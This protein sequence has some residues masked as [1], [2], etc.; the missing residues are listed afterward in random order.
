MTDPDRLHTREFA[1]VAGGPA[2]TR[3]GDGAVG[4]APTAL[5]YVRD[6]ELRADV[7]HDFD[8]AGGVLDVE[9]FFD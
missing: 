9:G 1:A 7:R 6:P 3:R 4:L 8:A 5:D 2:S